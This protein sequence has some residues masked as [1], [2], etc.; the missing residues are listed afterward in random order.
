MVINIKQAMDPMDMP[1]MLRLL[2]QFQRQ[3]LINE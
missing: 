2:L 1:F 3:L